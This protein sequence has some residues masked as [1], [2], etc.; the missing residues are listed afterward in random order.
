MLENR[1]VIDSEWS[2]LEKEDEKPV[3]YC[4]DCGRPIYE[5]DRYLDFHGDTFCTR[6]IDSY[7]QHA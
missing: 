6:C 1:M 2:V 5:G 3:F 4:A 7:F